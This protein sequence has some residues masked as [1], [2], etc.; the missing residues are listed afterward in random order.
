MAALLHEPPLLHHEDAVGAHHARKAMRDENG[1]A[2]FGEALER[3]AQGFL[4]LGIERGGG[5]VEQQDRRVAQEGAGN[6]DA[7]LLPAGEAP[8]EFAHGR[9]VALRK[10]AD[11]GIGL[12]RFRRRD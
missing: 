6:G 3:F 4:A 7:L 9:L 5:L 12:C 2:P 10:R 1:R 8:R 11:E